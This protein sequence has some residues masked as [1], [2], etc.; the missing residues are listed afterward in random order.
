M[1]TIHAPKARDIRSPLEGGGPAA[2][3][4]GVYHFHEDPDSLTQRNSP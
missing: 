1:G 3:G 4:R 2:G